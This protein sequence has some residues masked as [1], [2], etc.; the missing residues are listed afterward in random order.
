MNVAVDQPKGIG[1]WLVLPAIS[2]IVA[3]FVMLYQFYR[4]ILPL[5]S[6]GI[7]QAVTTPGSPAYDPLWAPLIIFEIS[8]NIFI[9]LLICLLIL[10]F[11]RKA[12]ITPKVFILFLVL[13]PIVQ[14][15]DY[16][17]GQPN[18]GSRRVCRFVRTGS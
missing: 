2:L 18:S 9:F 4:S 14:I 1:G 16:I 13:G 12:R 11:F 10:I 15:L 17:W 8:T 3:P 7:W 6:P 5:L